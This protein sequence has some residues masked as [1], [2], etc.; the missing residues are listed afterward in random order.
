MDNTKTLQSFLPWNHTELERL[1]RDHIDHG[2]E[3]SKVD[4]KGEIETTTPDKKAE[5]LRDIS[6]IA[7]TYDDANYQDY[8]FLIYGVKSKVLTGI[9]TTEP[10][11]DKFQ[12]H[13]EMLLKEY[14]SPMPQ[15][16][17]MGFETSAGAKWGAIVIPPRHSKPYMFF[18]E[19]G[20]CQD[21]KNNRRKGDWFV[22]RGATTDPGLPENLTVIS[23]RQINALLEPFRESLS[24]L[25]SRVAR[26]EELY[27]SE[28][29]SL[30]KSALSVSKEAVK[31]SSEQENKMD[32]AI[33][34]V[35]GLDLAARF[36][37]KLQ[38]PKDALAEDLIV[39][40]K[41]LRDFLS[42]STTGLPWAPQ[43]N[44]PAA[45]K[46]VVS[47][48]EEKIQPL[49]IAVANIVLYDKKNEYTKSLIEAVK[50]L[51]RVVEPPNSVSFN[52][53]G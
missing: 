30:V 2:T 14:I 29:F 13:I 28:L 32:A 23:R 25:Q 49:Q 38:T 15:I 24:T 46:G 19:I 1:L 52:N 3:T 31:P 53:I 36:K 51:A 27:H 21:P 26:T 42:G 34:N 33:G 16:Y 22:R 35:I 39:E 6:A 12:N 37:Q 17:V 18:K 40:T 47:L 20:N 50:L 41:A 7:N 11:T 4:L 10:D 8:G 5:L 9:T 43:L 48:L 44:D 45:S